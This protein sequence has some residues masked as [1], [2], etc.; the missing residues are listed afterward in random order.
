L[1]LLREK[2][3]VGLCLQQFKMIW[4]LHKDPYWEL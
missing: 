4:V 3:S 1:S 2:K